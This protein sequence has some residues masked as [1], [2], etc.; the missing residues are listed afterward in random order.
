[1]IGKTIAGRYQIG[2]E[3]GAG[4]MGTVYLGSDKQTQDKV[5]IKRL[6]NDLVQAELIERF[7]REGEAL[8]ELNHP[9]IVKLLDAIEDDGT[10]YLVMEYVSGGDL[11]D[12]LKNGEFADRTLPE[13]SP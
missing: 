6:N 1:M 10:H 7:K 11:S 9:N 4:G 2:A 5:A 13:I 8:R 3:L 12:L